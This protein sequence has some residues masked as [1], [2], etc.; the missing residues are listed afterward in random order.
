MGYRDVVSGH[1]LEPFHAGGSN[2]PIAR[3]LHHNR[4]VLRSL[5]KVDDYPMIVR[6]MFCT[7]PLTNSGRAGLLTTS[8]RGPVIFFGGCFGSFHDD[9]PQWLTKFERLLGRLC[10]E[11]AVV[12][13]VTELM[14]QHVYRWD[15]EDLDVGRPAPI[16]KWTF[17]GGPRDFSR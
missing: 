16:G 4:R 2:R 15:A 3:V 11:H 1:I 13:V 17:T 14:G 6:K 5:P 10:W 9:W 7:S 8:Y 12:V